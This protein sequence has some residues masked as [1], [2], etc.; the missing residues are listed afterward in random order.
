MYL[1]VG[2]G[3]GFFPRLSEFVLPGASL[4][5]FGLEPLLAEVLEEEG[6]AVSDSEPEG[7]AKGS[8]GRG[9]VRFSSRLRGRKMFS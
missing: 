9:G 5:R 2:L 6:L 8:S 1:R 3:L 4:S 7:A